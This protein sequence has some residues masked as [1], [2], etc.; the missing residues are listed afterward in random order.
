M[1]G[2]ISGITKLKNEDI[3]VQ[4]ITEKKFLSLY[5]FYGL[6]H[7][8][9]NIG[10]KI[11][12]D[13]EYNGLFMPKLRNIIQLGFRWEEDYERLYYWQQ[14]L[15]ILNQHLRDTDEIARFYFDLLNT[16]ALCL[17]KQSPPRVL[18][19]MYAKLLAFEGRNSPKDM[20]FICN[21]VL[22]SNITIA[23]GFL[24]AHKH[25]LVNN[26]EMIDKDKFF[27]FL[28]TK[29]S[30]LLDNSEVLYLLRILLLGI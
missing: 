14:F 13:I 5:R 27:H 16:G 24:P 29:Q 8:I 3:I 19:E 22:D 7:S 4:I 18:I 25:C 28:H 9:I 1:Q 15:K 2:F 17:N 20:C 21:R 6:R 12:F 30:I 23:R 10:R 11:D 26:N